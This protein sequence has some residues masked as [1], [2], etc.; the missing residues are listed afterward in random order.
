MLPTGA[1]LE[2]GAVV[3]VLGLV[4]LALGKALELWSLRSGDEADVEAARRR[5]TESPPS[6]RRE[7]FSLSALP[8]GDEVEHVA[9]LRGGEAALAELYVA[10]AFAAGWLVDSHA[11]GVVAHAPPPGSAAHELSL[12]KHLGRGDRT[13]SALREAALA[14]A[15]ERAEGSRDELL[16]HG[17][18]RTTTTRLRSV[19]GVL[20]PALALA[21]GV[22][23]V[24][25][26]GWS[27]KLLSAAVMM[28]SLGL[29]SASRRSTQGDA[30][31]AWLEETT[32]S[33]M[34]DAR[35]GAPLRMADV[36]LAAAL[37]V[38]TRPRAALRAGEA[39]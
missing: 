23:L 5:R 22:W 7:S 29:P 28:A 16:R 27:A 3:A 31:L 13:R 2:A 4:A 37:G 19:P 15:H 6:S 25:D 8:R 35:A 10:T 9:Y 12:A 21:L 11:S 14:A 20:A 39:G 1:E 33:L 17:L 32:S 24:A 36:A 18:L 26:V 38:Q 30:Y 34:A